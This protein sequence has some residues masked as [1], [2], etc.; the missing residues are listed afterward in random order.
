MAIQIS[1]DTDLF[2][3]F[4]NFY[5]CVCACLTGP[6]ITL[7]LVFWHLNL[8]IYMRKSVLYSS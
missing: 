4:I 3:L 1:N 7:E 2:C 8:L 6:V 5:V